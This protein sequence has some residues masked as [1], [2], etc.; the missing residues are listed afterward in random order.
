MGKFLCHRFRIE[1][2]VVAMEDRMKNGATVIFLQVDGARV[3]GGEGPLSN[4]AERVWFGKVQVFQHSR[5]FP[6]IPRPQGKFLFIGVQ[7]W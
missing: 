1:R 2:V 5:T 6:W 3:L 7:W 4:F